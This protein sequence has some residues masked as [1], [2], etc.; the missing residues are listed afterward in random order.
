MRKKI[1]SQRERIKRVVTPTKKKEEKSVRSRRKKK[2]G[3][4]TAW[5]G[6]GKE[7]RGGSGRDP[8]K[9]EQCLFM[10]SGGH[11]CERKKERDSPS[12]SGER[13]EGRKNCQRAKGESRR[14]KSQS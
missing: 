10:T 11:R 4:E 5:P 13:G 8:P 6:G 9:R 14:E 1:Q 2:G 12:H 3:P 7:N